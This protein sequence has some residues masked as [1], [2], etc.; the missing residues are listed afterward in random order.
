MSGLYNLKPLRVV[1][2]FERAGWQ[3]A[4]QTGSHIILSKGGHSSILTIP[5]HKGK[6]IK[7]GLLRKLIENAGMSLEEFLI[8]YK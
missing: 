7:Q 6:S 1:K 5:V 8:L 3:V 2:T 4:R